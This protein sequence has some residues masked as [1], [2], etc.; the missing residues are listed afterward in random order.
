MDSADPSVYSYYEK[1]DIVDLRHQNN[2]DRRNIYLR[3]GSVR[4]KQV[5]EATVRDT[6]KRSLSE[7]SYAQNRIDRC[8]E[9]LSEIEAGRIDDLWL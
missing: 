3:K 1:K 5:M 4:S 9:Q 6:I 7:I 8:K 2:S